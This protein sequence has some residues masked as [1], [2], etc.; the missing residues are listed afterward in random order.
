VTLAALSWHSSAAFTSERAL[1]AQAQRVAPTLPDPWIHGA[2][3]VLNAGDPREAGRWR[4]AEQLLDRA[5]SVVS[6]QSFTEQQWAR[7]AIKATTAVI[8]MRQGRLLEASALM[9]DA[10]PD[11]ARGRLCAHFRS[12][13]ALA[14]SSGS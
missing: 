1:W 7:D 5:R 6:S 9:Q 11:T 2:M 14:A 10:K 12:V 3:A 4:E 8:R 13:C